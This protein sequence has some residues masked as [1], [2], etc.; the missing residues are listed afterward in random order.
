M[1]PSILFA[2]DVHGRFDHLHAAV[3]QHRPRALILLGDI[4]APES[5]DQLM[6]PIEA[7]GT[8]V[9]FIPGNHDTDHAESWEALEAWPERNLHG[10]VVE[11]EGVRIAGLGGIFRGEI[12]YPREGPDE[13]HFTSLE[14][15][16]ADLKRRS[17]PRTW[18]DPS[19]RGAVLKHRSSIFPDVVDALAAQQADVLVTHEAPSCHPSGFAL[20]DDLGRA[21]G[22]KTL[23]HGHH[24]DRLDYSHATERLGFR[25]HGV[26]LCGI[27][28]LDGS[29]IHPGEL[30]AQRMHRGE[31]RTDP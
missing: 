17:A 25:A 7:L 5:L 10:R 2:G 20:L 15:F 9:W 31:E 8:S 3:L 29:V 4:E 23:F 30:D 16:T 13:P 28:A 22:I 24:H 19:K 1:S 26:G 6:A 12:W 27:T 11:I 21:L 14:D 18:N